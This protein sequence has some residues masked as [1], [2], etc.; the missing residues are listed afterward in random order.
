MTD[1]LIW[2]MA[3]AA[4]LPLSLGV[5]L[6]LWILFGRRA[7]APP[8]PERRPGIG[9]GVLRQ[10]LL[11]APIRLWAL[12]LAGPPLTM[13]AV[14]IVW[15]VR[16]GWEDGQAQQQLEILGLALYGA[17]GL[18]AIVMVSLAAV[19]L[20]AETRL[21]KLSIGRDDEDEPPAPDAGPW[22]PK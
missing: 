6:A 18:L 9:P 8:A 20:E 17:L 3:F 1:D 2:R 15:L 4:A 7:P 19:K 13:L 11:A 10:L 12:I 14:W 22:P 16:Y 5:A 21:G